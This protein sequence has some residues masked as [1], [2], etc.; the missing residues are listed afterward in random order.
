MLEEK[1]RGSQS[2]PLAEFCHSCAVLLLC[3]A[4]AFWTWGASSGQHLPQSKYVA[5]KA[6]H[7]LRKQ[8]CGLQKPFVTAATIRAA[9]QGY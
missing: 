8:S 2:K 4:V 1:W 7:A 6:W 9:P 3:A 5:L